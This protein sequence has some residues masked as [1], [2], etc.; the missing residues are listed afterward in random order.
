MT[1]NLTEPEGQDLAR[2]LIAH[3][4]VVVENFRTGN[5]TQYG[6]AYD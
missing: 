4:D 2:A 5:L 3:S 1:I 6:L